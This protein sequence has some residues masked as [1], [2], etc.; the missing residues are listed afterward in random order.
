MKKNFVLLLGGVLGIG[1]LL[2]LLSPVSH[3]EKAP[4]EDE[5]EVVAESAEPVEAPKAAAPTPEPVPEAPPP[6]PQ[7]QGPSPEVMK[8]FA[9]NLRALGTCLDTPSYVPGDEIDPSLQTLIDSI[10]GE[11]GEAVISTEDWSQIEMQTPE[12]EKRRLRVEMDFDNESVVQRKLKL[13]AVD[14]SGAT[15][16]IPVPE[17]QAIEP[18]ETTIASMESGNTILNRE[19]YER[20]YFQNGEEIVARQ[21]NGMIVDMEVNRGARSFKCAKMNEPGGTCQCIQ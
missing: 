20:H 11:W 13:M 8:N 5:V 17:E 2:Y 1:L 10:R 4:V 15:T 12:G 21:L 6:P 14:A 18:S 9:Q 19:K 3:E 16:P 7:P